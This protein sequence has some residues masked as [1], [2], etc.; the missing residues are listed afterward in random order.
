MYLQLNELLLVEVVKTLHIVELLMATA[1][2]AQ[3][4]RGSRADITIDLLDDYN[5]SEFPPEVIIQALAEV[6]TH[7]C[8]SCKFWAVTDDMVGKVCKDCDHTD[9]MD[10]NHTE[11]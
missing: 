3:N 8:P 7:R 9:L 10:N 6:G 4:L 11:L 5:L 2:L 1:S